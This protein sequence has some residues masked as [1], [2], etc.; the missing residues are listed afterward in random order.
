M[1]EEKSIKVVLLFPKGITSAC[2]RKSMVKKQ[3]KP[4]SSF[5]LPSKR[6]IISSLSLSLNAHFIRTITRK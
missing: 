1:F 6:Y 2:Y 3:H 4:I 5:P